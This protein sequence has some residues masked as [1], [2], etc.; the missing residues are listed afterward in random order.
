[1]VVE[2]ALLA[3]QDFQGTHMAV[4]AAEVLGL[5]FQV[6]ALVEPVLAV[7]VQVEL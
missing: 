3:L 5:D 4:E 6:Q 2:K 1:V 7:L